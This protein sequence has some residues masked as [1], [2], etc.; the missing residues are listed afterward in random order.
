MKKSGGFQAFN[1]RLTIKVRLIILF[2][3]IFTGFMYL[4]IY[5]TLLLNKIETQY[6]VLYENK[7][8]QL[9]STLEARTA[10]FQV[11]QWLTDS[12]A[13]G[14]SDGFDE[15]NSWAKVYNEN[16]DALKKLGTDKNRSFLKKMDSSFVSYH[17]FGEKMAHEYIDNGREAGNVVM[18]QFDAYA[19]DIGEKIE[20]F[21]DSQL[22]GVNQEMRSFLTLLKRSGFQQMISSVVILLIAVFGVIV[23]ISFLIK[24]LHHAV[25][26]IESID[27]DGS[28]DLTVRLH[29]ESEDEI[30]VLVDYINQFLEK[31]SDVI[32]KAQDN[33]ASTKENSMMVKKSSEE[34]TR[35]MEDVA[36]SITNIADG[37]TTQNHEV[38]EVSELIRGIQKVIESA[39]QSSSEQV[40]M[41]E[42]NATITEQIKDAM[43]GVAE[44]VSRIS[45]SSQQTM[46]IALN[47]Q[48]KVAATVTAINVIESKVNELSGNID[49]LGKSSDQ[50]GDIIN[51]ISEIASQTNLLALNAAIEAARAGEAGKGFAVVADEVRKLAERSAEATTEISTLIN[52]VQEVT[53]QSV[54]AMKEGTENVQK[55][56]GLA[57]EAK[58]SLDGIL[59]AVKEN[60]EQIQSISAST[61]EVAA[62]ADE[63]NTA[64][65]ALKHKIVV[66][67][68]D[69]EK[70]DDDSKNITSSMSKVVTIAEDNA[71][72]AEEVAAAS[73]EVAALINSTNDA[74]DVLDQKTNELTDM[75]KEFKV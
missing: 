61:E 26:G 40:Q 29:S 68:K 52:S 48:T 43:S 2:G 7:I 37:A 18:K 46:E 28:M 74:M 1:R 53:R 69:M 58:A 73:E 56:V 49:D 41:S 60:M 39:I 21:K 64:T 8:P 35:S 12:S 25:E 23:A 6:T 66:T 70:V 15:A 16:S 24:Q 44:D 51:V 36:R 72:N 65:E 59:K 31:F 33:G 9:I 17:K 67:T 54:G 30:N 3:F 57:D 63:I 71:A 32:S 19:A 45:D 47:G 14:W 50:I 11:Q 22:E 10:V 4:V 75:L 55:G 5:N 62:S 42:Q 13:T 27:K 34:S 20:G 38:S